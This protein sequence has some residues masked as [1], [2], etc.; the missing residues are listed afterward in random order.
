MRDEA[1]NLAMQYLQY[2]EAVCEGLRQLYLLVQETS[3]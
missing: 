2:I 1:D 3:V